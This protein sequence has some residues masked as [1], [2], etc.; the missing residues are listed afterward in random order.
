MAPNIG[1]SIKSAVEGARDAVENVVEDVVEKVKGHSHDEPHTTDDAGATQ[2]LEPAPVVVTTD[3]VSEPL[4]FERT[5]TDGTP[6]KLTFELATDVHDT[7]R[8]T[9]TDSQPPIDE[10]R[11][12]P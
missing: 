4:E 8:P 10:P 3:A 7:A 5:G 12:I 2:T 6:T 1:E 9:T 11:P